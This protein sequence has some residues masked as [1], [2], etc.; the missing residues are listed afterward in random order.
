MGVGVGSGGDAT[1]FNSGDLFAL[2]LLMS[3]VPRRRGRS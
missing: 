1:D 3:Q 2:A